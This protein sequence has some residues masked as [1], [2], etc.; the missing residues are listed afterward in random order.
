M[1]VGDPTMSSLLLIDRSEERIARIRLDAPQSNAL[2][3]RVVEELQRELRKIDVDP[4]VHAVILEGGED[5]FCS[6]ANLEM[7][8]A[9]REG[10]MRPTELGLALQILELS[11]PVIAACR[12]AAVGGGLALACACDHVVIARERRYGFNFMDLG[13][14]PGMGTTALAEHF[15]GRALAHEL[16]TTGEMRRGADLPSAGFHGIFES[17]EVERRAVLLALRIAEKPRRNLSMLKRTLT[18]QRRQRFLAAVTLESHMHE[19]TLGTLDLD[20]FDGRS[21]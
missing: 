18:L 19:T 4:S 20:S 10:S 11:V 17:A 21:G 1:D 12:G 3:P 2:S 5:V 14:T 13:I 6:G 8:E 15:F 7:L 16:L 9:L